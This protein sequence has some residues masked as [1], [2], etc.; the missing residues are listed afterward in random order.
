MS[1]KSRLDSGIIDM[2]LDKH[3]LGLPDN[4]SIDCLPLCNPDANGLARGVDLDRY[5]RNRK[6][7]LMMQSW[8][9]CNG[10]L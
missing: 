9:R 2:A 3:E 7:Y 5:H 6:T 10:R 4:Y 1:N 8:Q